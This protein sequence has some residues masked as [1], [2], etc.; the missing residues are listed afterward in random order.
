MLLTDEGYK[1][2]KLGRVFAASA[3]P[4]SVVEER[5]GHI[6][7]SVFVGHL[8]N[9]AAFGGKLATQLD[10]YKSR[11]R[12]LIFMVLGQIPWTTSSRAA[13]KLTEALF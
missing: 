9:A 3:L 6:T 11:G 12:D 1:E 10:P 4:T 5:G 13:L 2:A 7:S 8:G